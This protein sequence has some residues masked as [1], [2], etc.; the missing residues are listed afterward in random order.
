VDLH[1]RSPEGRLSRR[2]VRE[3]KGVRVVDIVAECSVVQAMKGGRAFKMTMRYRIFSDGRV[4]I[5]QH[6]TVHSSEGP[7]FRE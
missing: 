6:A 7:R 4:Q 3:N 1:Q 2:S 5:L